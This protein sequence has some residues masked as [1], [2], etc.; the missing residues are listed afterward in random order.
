[1]YHR[2]ESITKLEFYWEKETSMIHKY[3]DFLMP[4]N[5]VNHL[6]MSNHNE[7]EAGSFAVSCSL[8]WFE[9]NLD[10]F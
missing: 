8:L 2:I 3:N 10:T 1:M 9:E 6:S 4:Y 5:E 7:I